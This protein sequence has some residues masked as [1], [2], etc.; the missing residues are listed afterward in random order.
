MPILVWCS[1]QCVYILKLHVIHNNAIKFYYQILS[2]FTL[3]YYQINYS[4]SKKDF[5]KFNEC[6]WVVGNGY[7]HS[8]NTLHCYLTYWSRTS[9]NTK[10]KSRSVIHFLL[11]E[12]GKQCKWN[13]VQQACWL[14]SR[15]TQSSKHVGWHRGRPSPVS[16]L[17]GIVAD[18]L[19]GLMNGIPYLW[20]ASSILG[21]LFWNLSVNK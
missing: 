21:L 1:S 14:A 17:A 15:Q 4:L 10:L 19:R 16:M 9:E 20:D 6:Y 18:R 11:P 2:N 12:D 8:K 7:P 5:I 3:K 13:P